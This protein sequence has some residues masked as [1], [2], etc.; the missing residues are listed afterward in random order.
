MSAVSQKDDRRIYSRTHNASKVWQNRQRIVP[1]RCSTRMAYD[2]L[3]VL[4]PSHSLEDFPTE[5]GD[6]DAAGLLNAF[7]VLCNWQVVSS[8]P[9]H[10]GKV[11]QPNVS[12]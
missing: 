3:V 11:A 5:L 8:S 4:I 7:C 1:V 6:R 12:A 10:S 9:A 2:D